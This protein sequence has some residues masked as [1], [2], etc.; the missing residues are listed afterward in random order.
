MNL[1]TDALIDKRFDKVINIKNKDE[2]T[3]KDR[4]I[5]EQIDRESQI[6]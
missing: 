1:Y 4:K 5:D 3:A 6:K 2:K